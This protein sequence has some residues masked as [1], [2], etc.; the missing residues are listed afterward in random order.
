VDEFFEGVEIFTKEDPRLKDNRVGL[1]QE[2]SRF[3]SNLADFSKFS[4]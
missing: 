3:F 4:I 1:L 2:L